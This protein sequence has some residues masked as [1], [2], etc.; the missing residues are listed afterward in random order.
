MTMH[1]SLVIPAVLCTVLG[2]VVAAE[3]GI[4][5]QL[6]RPADIATERI[7]RPQRPAAHS[8]NAVPQATLTQAEVVRLAK[9]VAKKETGKKFDDYELKS[10][11]F[12]PQ[13]R[14][15]TVSFDPKPP[16]RASKECLT[17]FV[18]DDTKETRVHQCS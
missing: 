10:V 13:N 18:K 6:Q 7:D 3:K 1:K 14:E 4:P 11:I 8:S 17:V 2:N 16:R 15:W 9:T 12:D 5:P